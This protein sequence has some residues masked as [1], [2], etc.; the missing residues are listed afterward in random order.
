MGFL[1]EALGRPANETAVLLFPVGYPAA[2]AQVPKL[3]RKPLD[4]VSVWFEA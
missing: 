2:D 3:E 1:A 4:E